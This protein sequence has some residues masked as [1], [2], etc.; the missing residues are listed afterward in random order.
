MKNSAKI[1]GI[2]ISIPQKLITNQEIERIL[3]RP[4]TADWLEK[5]VGIKNRYIMPES[6]STS[7]LAVEASFNALHD[8][9][10]NEKD[11]DLIILSTDTPDYL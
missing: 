6:Q 8:A 3:N 5:N 10:I 4:G 11:I 1:I 2:G 7:D 9:R